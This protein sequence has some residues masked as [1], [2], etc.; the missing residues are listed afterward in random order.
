MTLKVIH[1]LQAFSNPIHRT[2]VWHFTRFQLTVRSHGTSALAELL[3][4]FI[5]AWMWRGRLNWLS[6]SF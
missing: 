5:L 2:F 1:Q 6:D 4:L 3:V